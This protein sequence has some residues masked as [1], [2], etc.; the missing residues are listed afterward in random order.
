VIDVQTVQNLITSW[1]FDYDQGDFERWPRYFTEGAH[2]SCRTDSGNAP[3]EE[4]LRADVHG[5]DEVVAWQID[6]RR[7]GPYPLRHNGTN[8]HV[9][10]S[11]RTECTF[12]SYIF[13][14]QI[15]EGKV[16]NVSSGLC[17]GK[18]SLEGGEAKIAELRII[19]DFTDSEIFDAAPRQ[20]PV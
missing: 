12:R 18:V 4:L 20:Q 9:D 3:Y 10:T 19:L 15:V 1:W 2:F 13:V 16:S 7:H 14:T 17:L 6:H 11:A 8:V 5:R